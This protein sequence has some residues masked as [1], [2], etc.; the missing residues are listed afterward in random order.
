MTDNNNKEF[1]ADIMSQIGPDSIRSSIDMLRL[2]A[3]KVGVS[4]VS[5]QID[6]L[7]QRYFYMLR[8]IASGNSVPNIGKELLVMSETARSICT[9]IERERVSRGEQTL[10][11]AQL[12]YQ[13][14]RP[15]EN[16]QSLVSDYLSELERLRTDS[17]SLTDSR[18]SA[19]LEQMASD[20]FMRLWVEMPLTPEDVELMKSIF[21]DSEIPEYDR[22]LWLGS[23]GLGLLF[24]EDSDRRKLLFYVL[25]GDS[26]ILSPIASVWLVLSYVNYYNPD[27]DV[28]SILRQIQS[29]YPTDIADVW[30]ELFRACGT[31]KLSDDLE[32]DVLSGMMD[33]GRRMADKFG[34]D[35]EKLEEAMRNG[36][37]NSGLDV[38]G[39]EKIK[40]FIEA[41]NR[42]DDVY[43][44]T[45]GK[46]RQFPFFNNIPNWF[47]PFHAGNSALADV[48]DGEGLAFADTVAKMPFLCDSDKYALLLSV[49]SAP[50]AMRENLLRNIVDRQ[51][52]MNGEM[53]DAALEEITSQGRKAVMSRY[54]KNLYR[55]FSLFRRKAE[56]P[57]IFD[58]ETLYGA[59]PVRILSESENDKLTS[60]AELLL[61]LRY[62][63]QA[64]SAFESLAKRE[65]ENVQA[66]QKRGYACE[67]AGDLVE[68]GYSYEEALNLKPGDK[69]TVRRLASVLL[70]AESYNDVVDL[71][72]PL[73]PEIADDVELLSCY[74]KS[75][76]ETGDYAR[77]LE[78]YYNVT[79]LLEDDTVKPE[80]AWLLVLNGDFDGAEATFADF[81]DKS[82]KPCDF[83][84]F[85]H[86]HWAKNETT[87]A[88]D[89]YA[90]AAGLV[91]SQKESF[92]E[93]F[94]D[95]FREI[96]SVL[97][98]SHKASLRTVPDI[99]AFRT[100]GSRFG[101]L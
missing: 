69:W 91:D 24:Y 79:Y 26:E 94:A 2:F 42:G 96:S 47:L 44:A 35:P 34:N 93:L 92:A 64:A 59:F 12:R 80:L 84:H 41:Q 98:S 48:T 39:F 100:Y 19:C 68:A 71:L 36:D 78:L 52:A 9:V 15:E 21:E 60:I 58:M 16:L 30:L 33:L 29:F 11:S 77:A 23:I 88:L 46:M 61:R 10:Y 55:F 17:A 4:S 99:I 65:P 45:L 3:A 22:V 50:V 53:L 67:L 38:N 89:A 101:K 25:G 31:K 62:Y 72:E 73:Q 81:I 82:T 76:Y 8:F 13:N 28:L 85:G 54:I 32:R 49:A 7:E 95:T 1:Y 97:D 43:M 75:A 66:F 6:E 57:N 86:L 37:W 20:I 70:K 51:N 83:I 56:F 18:R 74:A 14:L 90:K 5:S 27:D 87:A 40:G 63:E